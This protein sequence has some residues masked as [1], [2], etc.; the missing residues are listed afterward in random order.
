MTKK[1]IKPSPDAEKEVFALGKDN[2]KLMLI[3]MAV[4]VVGYVL[5]IGGGSEDPSKFNDAIFNFRRITL[6]PILALIG[7]GIIFYAIM[8][9][10][11]PSASH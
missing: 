8:K 10:K 3:G 2:F 9:K 5:M 6:A 11:K 7:Y 4:V 1:K